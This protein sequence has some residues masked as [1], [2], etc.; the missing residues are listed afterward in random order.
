MF[1]PTGL[2]AGEPNDS[3]NDV[4]LQPNFWNWCDDDNESREDNIHADAEF[5]S[6]KI[7][8]AS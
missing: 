2:I 6:R 1:P 8:D 4:I 5:Q 7:C 3:L